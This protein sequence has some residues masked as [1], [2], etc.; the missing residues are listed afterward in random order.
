MISAKGGIQM[1]NNEVI[2]SIMKTY[3][4]EKVRIKEN[5]TNLDLIIC[6]MNDSISLQ[7]WN[8]LESVLKDLSQ[9]KVNILTYHQAKR[10]LGDSYINESKVIQ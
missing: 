10:Y 8:L 5:S 2:L 1:L 9:K 7:R 4:I 6:E 3:D